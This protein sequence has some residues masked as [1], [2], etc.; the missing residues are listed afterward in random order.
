VVVR[1]E[2]DRSRIPMQFRTKA[3]CA[4]RRTLSEQEQFEKYAMARLPLLYDYN[5]SHEDLQLL[6][7]PTQL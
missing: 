2:K 7:S 6:F 5:F 4:E 1:L 3:Y